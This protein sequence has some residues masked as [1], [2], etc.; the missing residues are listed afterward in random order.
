MAAS[1]KITIYG[2]TYHIKSDS[3][4][5]DPH[6]VAALVDSKMQELSRGRSNFSTTDLAVLAALN[7][8]QEFL[9]T[10]KKNQ[11]EDRDFESR[12]DGLIRK[13]NLEVPQPPS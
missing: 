12:M 5:V 3:F 11:E 1:T 6:E 4:S 10:R 9:E 8:A 13:L 7:I 2:K